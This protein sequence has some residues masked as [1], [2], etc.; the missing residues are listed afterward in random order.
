MSLCACGEPKCQDRIL[1]IVINIAV[2]IRRKTT[3]GNVEDFSHASATRG[4]LEGGRSAN[5]GSGIPPITG[6]DTTMDRNPMR[7]VFATR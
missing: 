7:P 3:I 5:N 4:I 1:I 2:V 6:I